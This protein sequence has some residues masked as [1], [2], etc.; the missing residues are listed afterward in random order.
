MYNS[1]LNASIPDPRILLDSVVLPNDGGEAIAKGIRDGTAR[2]VSDGSFNPVTPI[3]PSG[4]SALNISASNENADVLEAV[5]WVP[6]TVIDQSAYRSELAGVCG[7]L[8]CL[9]IIV[10]HFDIKTGGITIALDG[11]SAFNQSKGNRPLS[12]SQPCFDMLQDIRARIGLLHIKITWKW[13]EGNQDDNKYV[14]LDRW[15][16]MNIK[17][18]T[19]IKDFFWQTALTCTHRESI[20]LS[21]CFTRNGL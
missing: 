15:A 11:E 21:N 8:A 12:I 14:A 7:I 9:S 17:M 10:Q 16:R 3:G 2:A 1:G 20:T 4:T 13:L 6:G 18:D 5:N 19:L